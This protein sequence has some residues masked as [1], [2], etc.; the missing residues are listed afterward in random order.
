MKAFLSQQWSG[1]LNAAAVSALLLASLSLAAAP[2]QAS[3][4]YVAS[5]FDFRQEGFDVVA[6]YRFESVA[7]EVDAVNGGIE[8]L[9]VKPDRVYNL[10]ALFFYPALPWLS[11]FAKGGVSFPQADHGATAHRGYNYGVGFDYPLGNHWAVTGYV[12]HY[13]VADD[14]GDTIE[15]ENLITLG[16][17][18]QF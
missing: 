2:A 15:V 4:P 8:R 17:K 7:L 3:G 9:D 13:K 6:G 12:T 18:Y 1:K 10:D 11:V 16:L 14:A 5:G